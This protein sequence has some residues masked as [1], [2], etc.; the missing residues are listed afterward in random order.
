M[1]TKYVSHSNLFDSL[2]QREVKNRDENT[3]PRLTRQDKG[4]SFDW[5]GHRMSKR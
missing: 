1:D 4:P 3:L 5:E 2:A